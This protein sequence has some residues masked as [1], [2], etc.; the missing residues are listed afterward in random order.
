M[1]KFFQYILVL[2]CIAYLI[3]IPTG[4]AVIIPPGG[5][6]KD[7]LPPVLVLS[8]PHDTAT[9][10]KPTKIVLTFDEFVDIKDVQTGL[11]VSPVPKNLPQVDRKLNKVTIKLKDSLEANTTYVFNFGKWKNR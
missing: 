11:I 2:F 10:V 1:N 3:K 6:P 7:T 9:N 4:C 8:E 5:G